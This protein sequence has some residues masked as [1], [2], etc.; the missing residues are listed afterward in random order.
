MLHALAEKGISCPSIPPYDSIEKWHDWLHD[1]AR[2]LEYARDWEQHNEY[3]AEYMA[4]FDKEIIKKHEGQTEIDEKYFAR[5]KE[6]YNEAEQIIAN[7]FTELGKN[8]FALW[9]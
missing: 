6:L 1:L 9:D 8:I 2:Q 7:V 5:E 3:A 4:Q